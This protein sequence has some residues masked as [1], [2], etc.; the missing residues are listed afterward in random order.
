ML[1]S[2]QTKGA[3]NTLMFWLQTE[4]KF[5]RLSLWL[6]VPIMYQITKTYARVH[7]K[8]PPLLAMQSKPVEYKSPLW[9]A[10]T[11]CMNGMVQGNGRSSEVAIC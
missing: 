8:T 11:D 9:M 6:P 7:Y 1:I 10:P 3:S 2:L 5:D 4:S